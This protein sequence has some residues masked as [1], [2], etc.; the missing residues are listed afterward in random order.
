MVEARFTFFTYL[1]FA[2]EGLAFTTASSSVCAFS[3]R[4]SSANETLPMPTWMTPVLSTRYSTLPAFV[5]RTAVAT[6]KV[7]VPVFGLGIRPR[8]PST[9][10]S[11]PTR[12]IMSG[13]AM[14]ASKSSQPPLMRLTASSPPVMSAPASSA[15]LTFSPCAMTSTRTV[16]PTPCG[17]TTVPRTNWSALRGSTPS[18]IV[19]STVS[20]NLRAV[21]AEISLTFAS[22]SSRLYLRP[23]SIFSRAARYFL[24]C[25]A[26]QKPLRCKRSRRGF[27]LSRNDECGMTNDELKTVVNSSFRIPHSSL[28]DVETHVARRALDGLDGR[29][30]VRRVQVLELELGDLL[31]L[32]ARDRADLLAVRLARALRDAGGLLQEVGRGRRLR[33]ERER[34]VGVDRDDD[35]HLEVR[36]HLRGLRVEGLA[37]LHDVNAVLAERRPDGR[38]GVRLPRRHLQLDVARN[39]LCHFLINR[40]P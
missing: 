19:S 15:S 3:R 32:V 12:R 24:P 18:H 6:S 27:S 23:S 1:P 11:C 37:E 22:P 7:T 25:L 31:D 10:P 20:S 9:L 28:F 4:E 8:G 17:S 26:I 34:A 29:F 2:V 5:S 40:E 36:V 21:T 16:F 38:R 14:T 33:L 39:L 30:E 13:V 35:R